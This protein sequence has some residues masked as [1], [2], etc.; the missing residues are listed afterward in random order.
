MID[1]AI[2]KLCEQENLFLS[3]INLRILFL[4][5]FLRLFI[6]CLNSN[7]NTSVTAYIYLLFTLKISFLLFFSQPIFSEY[8]N[9]FSR[10]GIPLTRFAKY[11]VS[12]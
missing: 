6:N 11:L 1:N 5:G 3:N 10:K 8:A 7:S 9:K 12:V 4:R 2:F